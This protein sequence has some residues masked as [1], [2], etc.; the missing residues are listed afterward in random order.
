MH[1]TF[2]FWCGFFVLLF[3]LGA[4]IGTTFAGFRLEYWDT[5]PKGRTEAFFGVG[6][7]GIQ[8]NWDHWLTRSMKYSSSASGWRIQENGRGGAKLGTELNWTDVKEANFLHQQFNAFLPFWIPL[9]GWI[10]LWPLW[11]HR[12]DQR[13]ARLYGNGIKELPSN[14]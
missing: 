6:S 14:S 11:M 10:V 12:G 8:G 4:W 9:L 13:Q 3:L 5:S 7:G 1:R 2:R